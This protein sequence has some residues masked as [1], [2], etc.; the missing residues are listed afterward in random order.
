VLCAVDGD[1][2][3]VLVWLGL[4]LQWEDIEYVDAELAWLV[5]RRGVSY[6]G[7]GVRRQE[8]EGL[9][10]EDAEKRIP[11]GGLLLDAL[12][13]RWVDQVAQRRAASEPGHRH[14]RGPEY[15][16]DTRSGFIF[17]NP[18]HGKPMN[19]RSADKAFAAIRDRGRARHRALSRAAAR[20]HDAAALERHA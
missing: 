19:P 11:I 12:R 1:P 10:N 15:Q 7:R 18:S 16:P 8:Q 13:R 20:L 17:T 5:V 4:G 14:W 9:K 2:L 6:L 3:E